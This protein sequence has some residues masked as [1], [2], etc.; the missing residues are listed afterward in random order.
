MEEQALARLLARTGDLN[1]FDRPRPLVTLEEYFEGN[2]DP[3]RSGTTC[4]VARDPREFYPVL[5]Q[6]RERPDVSTI[7]IEIKDHESEWPSS[8]TIYVVTSADADTAKSW[9]PEELAPDEW[10]VVDHPLA[11]PATEA[12][13]RPAGHRAVFYFYD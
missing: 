13:E 1:D 3:G 9:L 10:G 4:Q 8:D 2:D 7:L 12:Y 6:I 5:R 11:P